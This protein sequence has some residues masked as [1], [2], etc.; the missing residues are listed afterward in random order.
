MR[1][2]MPFLSYINRSEMEVI[3]TLF[4]SVEAWAEPPSIGGLVARLLAIEGVLARVAF[5][6]LICLSSSRIRKRSIWFSLVSDAVSAWKYVL[7][8]LKLFLRAMS[9]GDGGHSP[10][11]LPVCIISWFSR[12]LRPGEGLALGGPRE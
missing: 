12:G 6:S 10:D 11:E 2:A 9:M 1:R 3:Y 5:I 4:S 8:S 7:S